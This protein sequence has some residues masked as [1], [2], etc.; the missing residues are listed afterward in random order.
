MPYYIAVTQDQLLYINLWNKFEQGKSEGFDSL[1]RPSKLIQIEFK[2]SI[3][4]PVWP[5][6]L[7]DDLEK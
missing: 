2:S 7:M 1:D 6:N 5:W 3:F 4:P